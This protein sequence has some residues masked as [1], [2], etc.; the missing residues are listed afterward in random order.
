MDSDTHDMNAK[1]QCELE[2][3]VAYIESVQFRPASL[4][5]T[6][7]EHHRSV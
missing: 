1:T 7:H 4:K 5:E 6:D 3:F 2:L